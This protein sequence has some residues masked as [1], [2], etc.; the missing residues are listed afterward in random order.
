MFLPQHAGQA[1]PGSTPSGQHRG[2][3]QSNALNFWNGLEFHFGRFAICNSLFS[4]SRSEADMRIFGAALI[5]IAVLYG[6][7]AYFY[8]G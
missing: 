7:D 2:N 8:D 1:C 6:L 5:C 3:N 4:P